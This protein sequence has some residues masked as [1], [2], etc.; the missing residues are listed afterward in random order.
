MKDLHRQRIRKFVLNNE[1]LESR[2]VPAT[3]GLPWT[4][5]QHLTI[6]FA[7]DGAD[8]HGNPNSLNSFLSADTVSSSATIVARKNTI[9]K[10]FQEWSAQANINFTVVD[11]TGTYALGIPGQISSDSRF[12]DIRIGAAPLSNQALAISSPYD[13]VFA[14]TNSGD[15]IFNS[16]YQL[17]DSALLTA[18]LHEIGHVLG[19]EDSTGPNSVLAPELT[20]V[21]TL[22]D[23]DV[24]TVQNLYGSRPNDAFDALR[25]NDTVRN[26][27]RLGFSSNSLPVIAFGDITTASD[28]DNYSFRVPSNYSGAVS[29]TLKTADFSLLNGSITVLDSNSHVLGQATANVDSNGRAVIHLNGVTPGTDYVIQVSGADPVFSTGAYGLAIS[30]DGLS[31]VS[32]STL[33]SVLDGQ[34][35]DL[36]GS[37]LKKLL[38]GPT[39]ILFNF[40]TGANDNAGS[41]QRLSPINGNSQNARYDSVSSLSSS[42]DLDNYRITGFA[43]RGSVLTLTVE[44]IGDS[45]LNPIINLTTSNGETLNGA[46]LMNDG[47]RITIQ[48]LDVKSASNVNIEVKSQTGLVGNYRLTAQFGNV[49]ANVVNYIHSEISTDH[50]VKNFRFYNGEPQLFQFTS[51]MQ[52]TLANSASSVSFDIINAHGRKIWSHT[53]TP[54]IPQ[55]GNAV[56][57]DPGIYSIQV[58]LHSNSNTAESI[59]FDLFGDYITDPIGPG[60]IDSTIVPQFTDPSTPGIYTFEDGI[61]IN[62][63]YIIYEIIDPYYDPYYFSDDPYGTGNPGNENPGSGNPGSGDSGTGDYSGDGTLGNGTLSP[64][65]YSGGGDSNFIA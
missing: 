31:S 43:N 42:S 11:E 58:K 4:T 28:L 54:G 37:D 25:S 36:S 6:S 56:L 55:S 33:D 14:G 45:G 41:A 22:S 62:G 10:A 17:N 9:L 18:T 48:A 59:S 20:H 50:S 63:S 39:N 21:S 24:A 5:P 13:P 65:D 7:P 27:S 16:N 29:I 34:N 52:S 1:T 57:I 30:L 44:T 32:P 38:T 51:V 47:H 26:A 61:Y 12:G 23:S 49:A 3:F 8:I 46:V 64:G 19:F 60:Y 2:C 53:G 35:L 40:E 15:I